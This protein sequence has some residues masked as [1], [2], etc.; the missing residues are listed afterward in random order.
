M[1]LR[2]W[3]GSK[4]GNVTTRA[5]YSVMLIMSKR[6]PTKKNGELTM[7]SPRIAKKKRIMFIYARIPNVQGYKFEL[8]DFITFKLLV[9]MNF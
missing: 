7:L 5:R 2:K 6:P 1:L 3:V 4:A 9:G 8:I